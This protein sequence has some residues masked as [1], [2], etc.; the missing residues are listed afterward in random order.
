MALDDKPKTTVGEFFAA[1]PDE[2]DRRFFGRHR[3]AFGAVFRP[4]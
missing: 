4:R 2:A 3:F 1:N